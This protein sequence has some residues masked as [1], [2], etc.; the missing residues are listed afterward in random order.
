MKIN[1]KL[2]YQPQIDDKTQGCSNA[3]MDV[4][5]PL[6][7]VW[8]AFMVPA[9]IGV[10]W[11]FKSVIGIIKQVIL[12]M[13]MP[14]PVFTEEDYKA[15]EKEMKATKHVVKKSE[16]VGDKRKVT[17]KT[18]DKAASEIEIFAHSGVA[19]IAFFK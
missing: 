18:P 1:R 9:A 14:L 13:T 12:K 17:Y 11:I 10:Y 15:A 4:T 3:M 8:I 2:T 16:N 6:M 7:S 19:S 5:M